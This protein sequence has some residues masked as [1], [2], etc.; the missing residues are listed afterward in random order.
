MT[1][2]VQ[3]AVVEAVHHLNSCLRQRRRTAPDIEG[4]IET[5]IGPGE[6]VLHSSCIHHA[7]RIR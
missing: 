5:K 1:G 2:D 4:G 7:R 3:F 6:N